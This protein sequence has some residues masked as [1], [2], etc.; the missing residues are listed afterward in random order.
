MAVLFQDV[1]A[2][3]RTYLDEVSPKSWTDYEVRREV[4]NGY[5]EL[6]TA[7]IQ[8]FEDYYLRRI[9]FSLIASQQEYGVADGIP[10]DLY[11]I[12]RIEYNPQTASNPNSFYRAS[13]ISM[14]KFGSTLVNS[15]LGTTSTPLYYT[16]GFANN[17]KIGFL[18]IPQINS[19]N[20]VRLWH[21]YTVPMMVNDTDEVNIPYPERYASDISL[22]AAGVLL[23]K[24]QQEEPVA[25]RYL[26]EFAQGKLDMMEE[27]RQRNVDD[28]MVISDSLGQNNDFGLVDL[29][30]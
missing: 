25:A 4:N 14:N 19:T 6:I 15:A 26:A 29:Y 12:K 13:P 30:Y 7:T 22:Y 11:K 2:Q 23:R 5:G 8:V 24:G 1:I 20:G 10:A 3:T 16:Y 18:P 28:S 21:I 27:L 17:I 9:D